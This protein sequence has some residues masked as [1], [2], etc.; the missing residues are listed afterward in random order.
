MLF[1][2]GPRSQIQNPI[3]LRGA[4]RARRPASLVAIRAE[5]GALKRERTQHPAVTAGQPGIAR[6]TLA[7]HHLKSRSRKVA[8]RLKA[9]VRAIMMK[10]NFGIRSVGA[11]LQ[12]IQAASFATKST[13]IT[14]PVKDR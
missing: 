12:A 7:R 6:K 14:R 5:S 1:K 13:R 8:S 11:C 10:K 9:T 2:I 3:S 4:C